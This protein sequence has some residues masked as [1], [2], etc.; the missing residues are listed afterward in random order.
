MRQDSLDGLSEAG[1]DLGEIPFFDE[2]STPPKEESKVEKPVVPNEQTPVGNFFHPEPTLNDYFKP[3][4]KSNN[5]FFGG[6]ESP[7]LQT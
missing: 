5:F 6:D 7:E 3:P 1:S 4:S 2:P